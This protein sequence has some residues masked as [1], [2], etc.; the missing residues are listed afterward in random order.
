MG[1]A[2]RLWWVRIAAVLMVVVMLSAALSVWAP[3]GMFAAPS[4]AA[5][6]A[7]SP[8][9]LTPTATGDA[10]AAS[11]P[12]A[13]AATTSTGT[14]PTLGPGLTGPT[15]PPLSA[16]A[17]ALYDATTG[18][19]LLTLSPDKSVPMAST[20]KIMTAVVAL[21]Y[22]Q[23]DQMI[24]VGPDAYAIENDGTSVAGLRLGEKLSL[25]E[26]LYC[27]M[28]PS[29]DDAAIA[30]ADGVAGSQAHFV[31]LMNLEAG[32]LG[33]SH[34]HYANPHGLDALE[35]YTSASDLVRL[36][37]FAMQSPTFAQ[38]VQTPSITLLA[39]ATH[40][41]LELVNTNELLRTERFAYDG[42]IGIKTGYTG[43]A[44][45]CLVFMAKRSTGTLIGVVLGEPA[46]D[47]RFTDATALL[48]WGYQA[49]SP[50]PTVTPGTTPGVTPSAS[51]SGAPTGTATATP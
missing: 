40:H 51:P 30:I 6:V 19:T 28:L 14:L 17:A 35:H 20:T 47:G 49:L 2:S 33:L 23:L 16:T 13:S 31:A 5:R 18:T 9:D 25:Q 27:L 15:P 45:Y 37:E 46:Y 50:T 4:H 7:L 8:L 48:N 12:I 26:L 10:S 42:A 43:G 29:G 1:S 41:Q 3:L 11:T 32:L 22:G 34:T 44:G 38:V 21:T 36:T 24:T 39:T